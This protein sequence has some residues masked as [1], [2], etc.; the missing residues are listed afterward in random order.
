[1]VSFSA[2]HLCR[3]GFIACLNE[4]RHTVPTT[5]KESTTVHRNCTKVSARRLA[6]V[7]VRAFTDISPSNPANPRAASIL[8]GSTMGEKASKRQ[9]S[10]EN[11]SCIFTEIIFIYKCSCPVSALHSLG[12][13]CRRRHINKSPCPLGGVIKTRYNHRVELIFQGKGME[14]ALVHIEK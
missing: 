13:L 9:E 11:G 2:I 10:P 6:S 12:R 5:H 3:W 4:S 1:M 14:S 8:C 7:D